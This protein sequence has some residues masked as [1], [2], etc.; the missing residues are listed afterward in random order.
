MSLPTYASS[1]ITAVTRA[2]QNV[3][4]P[5]FVIGGQNATTYKLFKKG[6]TYGFT[7]FRTG[8]FQIGKNFDILQIKF[9]VIPN[10]AANMSIIPVLYFDNQ[11][12][13]SVGTTINATN[14]PNSEKLIILTA[15]NFANAVHG[16]NNFFL[17]FQ[18]TGT[19][20]TVVGLPINISLEVEDLT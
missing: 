11:A 16:K 14:Y 13:N 3:G 17:E 7:V 10:M 4:F 1:I 18:I 2:Q 20:L 5:Q 19:V 8:V 15:K 6:T 12:T 9:P